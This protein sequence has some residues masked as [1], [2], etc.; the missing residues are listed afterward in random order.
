MHRSTITH[1]SPPRSSFDFHA[2][3]FHRCGRSM[4]ELPFDPP[5][6]LPFKGET[7][8]FTG[9]LWSLGRKDAR[10]H[11]RTSSAAPATT[12]SRVGRRCSSSARETY[13]GRR[14]PTVG[15]SLDDTSTHEPEAA[16][17]RADQRRAARPH[18]RHQRRRVLPPR[19]ACPSIAELPR[20]ST[21]ASATSWR[22]TRR[23]AK[24]TCA[25]CRSGASSGRRSR[26][27]PT[28][29]LASAI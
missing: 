4:S 22:C 10:S 23:C 26:T 8:V 24:T 27:T 6:G 9:K 29:S 14:R 16:P 28:R 5:R 7:V 20:P 1:G 11:R 18:P 3:L 12:T 19:R 15:C 21:T 25:T 17:R 13:P 2:K